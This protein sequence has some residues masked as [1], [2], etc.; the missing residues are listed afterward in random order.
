MSVKAVGRFR[1][2]VIETV[3][4]HNYI[5]ASGICSYNCQDLDLDNINIANE[6]MSAS[7]F[8]RFSRYT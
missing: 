3:G 1:G 6:L 7:L 2:Y 4:T 8:G 5:L